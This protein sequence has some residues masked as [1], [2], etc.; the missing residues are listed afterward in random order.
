MSSKGLL[1]KLT[2][3]EMSTCKQ[4]ASMRWQMARA[5][6]VFNQRKDSRSDADIDYLGIRAEAAVAKAY[7]LHH[8]PAMNGIDDGADLFDGDMSIDVK[9]T[10]HSTGH[11]LIKSKN[12]VKADLFVLVTDTPDES[13]MSILGWTTKDRFLEQ[14]Q[15]TDFANKGVCL[16]LDQS[17]LFKPADLWLHLTKHKYGAVA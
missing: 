13:V 8:N 6:G 3:Q 1:I 14:A 16:T 5:S 12:A 15:Q 10:F 11:L 4:A 17:Q 2:R 7:G 9:G